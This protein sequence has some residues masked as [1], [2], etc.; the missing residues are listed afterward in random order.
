MIEQYV[1]AEELKRLLS[2]L[3]VVLGLLIIAGLF[4]S[5]LVPGL[6]NANR[7]VVQATV[8]P[9][10][11]EPGWLDPTEFPP[12]RG[13]EVPPVD[14]DTLIRFSP[15]LMARGDGLFRQ[16]C[17]P[18]HGDQGRGDG[19]AAS[20]LNPRPRN[21]TSSS[22][23]TN[24]YD[25][26]S[27]YKTLTEGVKGTGMAS[28]DYLSKADRMALAHWVQGLG[29]FA[30]G[31]GSPEALA[32]LSKELASQGERTL[33]RIPVSMAITKLQQEFRAAPPLNVDP[34]DH[35]P[36]AEALR[37]VVEDPARA[38]ETLAGSRYWQAGA[39][40]LA[41]SILADAPANGFR[42]AAAGLSPSD[43]QALHAELVKRLGASRQ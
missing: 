40:E 42:V 35:S 39:K 31:S 28:F 5:I 37:G 36:G 27:I 13:H 18:C 34:A 26:P 32:A 20:T 10:L 22:G 1:N 15:T 8:S 6:R 11:G 24:G 21:F 7:P 4:A 12:T 41:D 30:P 43:W 2:S 38:A 17:T 14:P 3:L 33:N 19:P 9:V 25:L 23:W 16:N 29:S